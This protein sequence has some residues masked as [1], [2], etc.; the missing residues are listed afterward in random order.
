M[1][2]RVWVHVVAWLL[3]QSRRWRACTHV[4]YH[5]PLF[6]PY[7]MIDDALL[8]SSKKPRRSAANKIFINFNSY[9]VRADLLNRT[10]CRQL[11]F[12]LIICL[13]GLVFTCLMC[14]VLLCR[15]RQQK[16][17]PRNVTDCS[18]S[19]AFVSLYLLTYPS[20]CPTPKFAH[21]SSS[22]PPSTLSK[23]TQIPPSL[24]IHEFPSKSSH[25]SVNQ[26][27]S[28]KANLHLCPPAS[29]NT[30]PLLPLN[31]P[32]SYLSLSTHPFLAENC[33]YVQC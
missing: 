31:P 12:E 1:S 27:T 13:S 3:I 24:R 33:M 2:Q 6:T 17:A 30:H 15:A 8:N 18:T 29:I 10:A 20:P 23:P 11:W 25:I 16:R 7:W 5:H 4:P 32:T 9:V 14:S 26:S 21:L 19:Y 28:Y 22:H